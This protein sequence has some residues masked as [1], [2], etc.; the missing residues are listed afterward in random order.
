MNFAEENGIPF[1]KQ[2]TTEQKNK[3]VGKG[4]TYPSVVEMINAMEIDPNGADDGLYVVGTSIVEVEK[5][6]PKL[7]G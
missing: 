5:G 1:K 7:K 2:F 4:K 6:T 3:V